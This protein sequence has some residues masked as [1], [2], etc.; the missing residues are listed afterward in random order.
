MGT[1]T[2]GA[3]YQANAVTVT[4][5]SAAGAAVVRSGAKDPQ[6]LPA[7]SLTVKSRNPSIASAPATLTFSQGQQ[8]SSIPVTGNAVGQTD[9]DI[10]DSQ[11]GIVATI[12]VTVTAAATFMCT[13]S[14]PTW[15]FDT[16]F[17][18]ISGF[19][20]TQFINLSAAVLNISANNN[21]VTVSGNQPSVMMA[22]G[23]LNPSTC[24]FNAMGLNTVAGYP[25]IP[26]NFVNVQITSVNGVL[27]INGKVDF[28]DNHMLPGGNPA[29][30]N[31]TGAGK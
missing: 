6:S 23:T 10:T 30:Y 22:T 8:T 7:A 5:G 16:K 14:F 4:V 1:I 25:N 18:I 12:H 2:V 17:T 11:S 21:V 28:G 31:L 9:I 27:M 15:A 26:T 19:E 13:S 20:H 24:T 3:A 29:I